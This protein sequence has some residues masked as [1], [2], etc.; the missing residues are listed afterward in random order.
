MYPYRKTS[1]QLE[2][3]LSGRGK[4]VNRKAV[5]AAKEKAPTTGINKPTVEAGHPSEY[6]PKKKTRSTDSPKQTEKA[7]VAKKPFVTPL[8]LAR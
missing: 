6:A 2:K 1:R 4:V 7:P 5:K 3:E 8:Q